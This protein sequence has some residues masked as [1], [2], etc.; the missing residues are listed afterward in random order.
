[1]RLTFT[2]ILLV[3]TTNFV[4]A[5]ESVNEKK[6]VGFGCYFS[7]QPTKAVVKVTELLKAKKYKGVSHLLK[8]GNRA[9]KFLAVVS[10]EKLARL[11]Q[12][13]LSDNEKA[14]IMKIRASRDKVS[15]CSGCTYFDKVSLKDMFSE[16]NFLGSNWW[17]EKTLKE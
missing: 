2:F 9:E 14:L 13:Q 11:E 10:L 6:M 12:Y 7:G 4:L 15:V 5:Q 3:F 1:M 16:H 8:T 17:I